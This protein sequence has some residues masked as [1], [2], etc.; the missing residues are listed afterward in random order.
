MFWT[1]E[2]NGV[3]YNARRCKHV[4]FAP[5]QHPPPPPPDM[6]GGVVFSLVC[7]FWYV[8]LQCCCYGYND[9]LFSL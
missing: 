1:A 2:L 6:L 4:R 7:N 5:P 3:R 9:L 8:N